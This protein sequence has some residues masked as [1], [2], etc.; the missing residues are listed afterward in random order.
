MAH[1]LSARKR[2]RQN[3]TRRTRNKA[4]VSALK[5]QIRKSTAVISAGG[6]LKAASAAL[7]RFSALKKK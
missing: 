6:D 3:A 4:R 7:C 2:V 1:S 5:S